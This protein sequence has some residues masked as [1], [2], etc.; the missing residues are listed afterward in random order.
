MT[1][2]THSRM[3]ALVVTGLMVAAP[4]AAQ[5]TAEETRSWLHVQIQG[6]GDE[7]ERV[8]L[9]LPLRAVGAVMAMAPEEIISADGRLTVAEEHGVSVSEIRVMWQELMAAGDSEFATVQHE[10]QT[11]RVA[12]VGERIEVRV[13]GDNGNVQVDLPT[14]VV[15]ALLSGEGE[16]LNIAAALDRLSEL[17]GDIVRVI[18]DERQIRVWVDENAEQ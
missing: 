15:D 6:D 7:A 14:L 1:R 4:L 17:R 9:N 2:H 10:D 12:R 3:L 11:V 5:D 16:M 13:H 18:E 8:A